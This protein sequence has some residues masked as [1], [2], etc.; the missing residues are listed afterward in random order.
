MCF[1]YRTD[2]QKLKEKE[3]TQITLV[4]VMCEES[5]TDPTCVTIAASPLGNCTI[6]CEIA[7]IKVSKSTEQTIWSVS[8]VSMT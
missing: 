6:V 7:I 8:P 4:R 1:S 3:G 2:R 5:W